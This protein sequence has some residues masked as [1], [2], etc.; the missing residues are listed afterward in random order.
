ME[1]RI[2]KR[3]NELFVGKKVKI[4]YKYGKHITI[5][6][7]TEGKCIAVHATPDGL[8]FYD[9]E[10]DGGNRYGITVLD[11]MN[12]VCHALAGGG[13]GGTRDIEVIDE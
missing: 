10:L 7:E 11:F 2:L 5:T 6:E 4:T 9:I 8:T 12:T 3:L 13:N 1:D